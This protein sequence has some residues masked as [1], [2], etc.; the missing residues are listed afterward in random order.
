MQR[1]EHRIANDPQAD[2][3][4]KQQVLPGVSDASQMCSREAEGHMSLG[5]TRPVDSVTNSA[6]DQAY[7]GCSPT[8]EGLLPQYL[9]PLAVHEAS[10]SIIDGPPDSRPAI[11]E[12]PEDLTSITPMG[13]MVEQTEAT[14]HAVTAALLELEQTRRPKRQRGEESG[15]TEISCEAAF[16]L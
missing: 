9:G 1:L 11:Y 16:S 13:R 15:L 14:R 8:R 5:S 10:N 4:R 6:V 7:H 3:Q 12:G 2:D